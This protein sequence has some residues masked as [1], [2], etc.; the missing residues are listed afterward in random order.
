LGSLCPICSKDNAVLQAKKNKLEE[1]D[2]SLLNYGYD[3][4]ERV[5]LRHQ[6]IQTIFKRFLKIEA[7]SRSIES[8]FSPRT[9][10]R[11]DYEPYYQR[12]YVWDA[13]KGTY[14]VESILIGTEVPPLI[15]Y[16]SSG[17]SEVIDG[18]Q[19]FETLLRFHN[20]RLLL[21]SKGLS[22]L[23]GLANCTFSSLSD[24]LRDLFFDTKVRII[25]FT[26][27]DESRF[28]DRL[29][30]MLK[31]EVFRRYNSGITPLRRLDVERAVYIH[32]D[33]TNYFKQQFRR[34]RIV[35]E[36]MVRLFLAE[37][38]RD[39]LDAKDTRHARCR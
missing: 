13:A 5:F 19:R 12:N 3:A 25:K 15:F 26:V 20:E 27:V 16:E 33:P 1:L 9:L 17:D 32:D 4:E 18:R 23:T 28:D 36:A 11:I 8:L 6:E 2:E 38:D 21:S 24:E 30:D 10:H 35:Y 29:Q 34:N 39:K 31:K 14:F 22:T 37:S 7:E